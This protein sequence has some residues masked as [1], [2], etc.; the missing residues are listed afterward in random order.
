[1][2]EVLSLAAGKNI[3]AIA[4][5]LNSIRAFD[6]I[7]LLKNGNIEGD[8]SFQELMQHNLYFQELYKAGI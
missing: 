5:R 4:H 8:G 2:N 1:M 3:I 7:I 6:R